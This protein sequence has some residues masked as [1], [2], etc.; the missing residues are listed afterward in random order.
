MDEGWNEGEKIVRKGGDRE[1]ETESKKDRD[2]YKGGK[3][4]VVGLS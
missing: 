1:S 4:R 2:P 3:H